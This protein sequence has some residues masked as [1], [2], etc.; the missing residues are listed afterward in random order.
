[1][2]FG[3]SL[4]VISVEVYLSPGTGDKFN[5]TDG[6]FDASLEALDVVHSRI[7][8]LMEATDL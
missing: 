8:A 7:I 4:L 1:M 6:D 3:S 2:A 5:I